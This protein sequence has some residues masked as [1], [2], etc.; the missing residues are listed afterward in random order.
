MRSAGRWLGLAALLWPAI[1]LARAGGGQHYSSPPSY[2]GGGGYGGGGYSG[3][4][5]YGGGGGGVDVGWLLYWLFRLTFDYPLVMIPFWLIVAFVVYRAFQSRASVT[6]P[7]EISRIEERR[8][9]PSQDVTSALDLLRQQDPAFDP[10]AF[11]E[12][13]RKVFL[14][15]QEAWFLRNLDP[16]RAYMSDGVYRRFTTLLALMQ[17]EN[18]RNALADA[19]VASARLLE[20]TRTEAFDC[21]TV[22]VHAS[23]RDTDVPASDSD[24]A[25][26][27]KAQ[28]APAEEFTELW[29][30]IRRRGRTTRPRFDASQGHCPNC[31]APF[32]GGAANK[33]EYC[34][35]I[36]NSGNYDWVLSEITQASEYLP[37][38]RTA[39]GLDALRG[40]DPDAAAEILQDRAL[41][42]FWKWLDACAFGDPKRIQKVATKDAVAGIG[43]GIDEMKERKEAFV[44]RIPAVGGTRVAAVET[45]VG[46]FDRAHVEIRW[47]AVLG[48][49]RV[50]SFANPQ[51]YRSIVTMVRA[52]SA[53][54]DRGVGLSNERC[55]NCGAPLTNS[56][57]TTCDFC[58]NDLSE[59]AKNWQLDALIPI[60]QWVRPS[61]APAPAYSAFAT[62]SERLRLLS[63]LVA[64]VKADGVVEPSELRMLRDSAARWHVP[65]SDVQ[66]MLDHG[67]D[68]TF[69][70][71]QPQSPDQ[72][73]AFLEQL[74]AAAKV[75]GR[76]DRR[77]RMLI[78]R[79][80]ERMGLDAQAVDDLID[81]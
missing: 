67:V 13:T 43:G 51:P 73:S 4:G 34:N 41:L 72:A 32:T 12:R 36:V 81:E 44:V 76:I 26:R 58:G 27:R 19:K 54:T 18:Q 68:E 21:L 29:T 45:D 17:L 52:S 33:C 42:L 31:G 79:A 35:A 8:L 66:A 5:G 6:T 30:F 48:A 39:P 1:V 15:I 78:H 62:R 49:G 53:K 55:G 59:A 69:G 57:S 63:V 47:S 61:V 7:R 70:S 71:L 38:D 75:D 74:I 77:E 46:G 16:V 37:H 65:W 28:S 64:I 24:E 23:M 14:Q 10:D 3:Y 20:V 60:E 25:A 9:V 11:F 56:D 40:R 80:G 50:S 2:G 22:R